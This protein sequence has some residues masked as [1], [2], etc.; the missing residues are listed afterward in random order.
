MNE[1][2]YMFEC[3]SNSKRLFYV[4][5]VGKGGRRGYFYLSENDQP[6]QLHESLCLLKERGETVRI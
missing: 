3:F 1:C 2:V 4:G 5:G 6:L